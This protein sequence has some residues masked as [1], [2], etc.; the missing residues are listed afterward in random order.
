MAERGQRRT[1]GAGAGAVTGAGGRRKASGGVRAPR[2]PTVSLPALVPYGEGKLEAEGDYDGLEF[3]DL[4]L[5]DQA[6]RGARFLDCALRRCGLDETVLA[7]ARFIDS[8][9]DG[10]HGVG[11]DL[12]SASLRD[13]ELTDARFGGVQAH[14]GAW[15]RVWVRGGKI[16]YLNLRRTTLKDVTFEGCVLVEADFGD[17]TLER[18]S[19]TGCVLRRVD[20]SAAQMKDVDLRGVTEL[21]IARGLDALAGAT[22]SPTQLL[23]LAPAFATQL[24]IRVE[25]GEGAAA[26]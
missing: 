23:D 16:D 9:L 24:G 2:R 25:Q 11:T 3:T 21:D 19:F 10:V 5:R 18:V 17:A 4:D 12:T 8:A 20:F 6:G 14:G 26:E 13:V 22:I 1:G 7:G 15:E